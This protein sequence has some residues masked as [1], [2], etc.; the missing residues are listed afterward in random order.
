MAVNMISVGEETGLLEKSLYKVADSYERQTAQMSETI[1]K[2][3][4]MGVLLVI[5][6]FV[7]FVVICMLLPLL[8]LNLT[9]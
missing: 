2:L 7:G 1:L 8:S 3:F 5:V 9:M 4:G 6:V